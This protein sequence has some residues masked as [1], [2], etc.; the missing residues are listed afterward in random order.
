MCGLIAAIN[1]DVDSGTFSS[2]LDS[3]RRRGPDFTDV[4]HGP[5]FSLVIQDYLS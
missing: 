2:C 4:L 1:C 5:S 3:L